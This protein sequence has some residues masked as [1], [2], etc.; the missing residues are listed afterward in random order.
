MRD[1]ATPKAAPGETLVDVLRFILQGEDD[2]PEKWRSLS[3]AEWKTVAKEAS[4]QGLAPLLY[5]GIR[6]RQDLTAEIPAEVAEKLRDAFLINTGRNV[7]LGHILGSVIRALNRSGIPVIVLK[8]LYLAEHIHGHIG[9]RVFGDL[10]ILVRPESLESASRKIVQLGF[11]PID[12]PTVFEDDEHHLA[13]RHGRTGAL[14]ELHWLLLKKK[15]KALID[16]D[17]LWERAIRRGAGDDS[18]FALSP[19]DS[20]A[21][22]CLHEA[23]HMYASR[24]RGLV[25]VAAIVQRHRS[26]DWPEFVNRVREWRIPRPAFFTLSLA[27]K[28]LD[29]PIPSFVFENLGTVGCRDEYTA[30]GRSLMLQFGGRVEKPGLTTSAYK[31]LGSGISPRLIMNFVRL[32]FPPRAVLS[33]RYAVPAKSPLI[34]PYYY[35]RLAFLIWKY[36]RVLWALARKRAGRLPPSAHVQAGAVAWLFPV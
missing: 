31:Y 1:R 11:R 36:R 13:F 23:E 25:D 24:L 33:A 15:W 18:C 14:L 17:G 34:Y 20:L 3:A 19:A 35:Y 28:I 7:R 2:G 30:W 22:V 27:K 6:K 21:F 29:A 32:S 26:L 5:H 10:D 9:A 4:V 16:Y 8:G 12:H